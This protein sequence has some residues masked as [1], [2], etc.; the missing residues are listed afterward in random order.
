MSGR[1][2]GVKASIFG[3]FLKQSGKLKKRGALEP[4]FRHCIGTFFLSL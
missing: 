4:S 3:E 2:G 1:E